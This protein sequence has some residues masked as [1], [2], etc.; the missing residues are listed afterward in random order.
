MNTNCFNPLSQ[1]SEKTTVFE[2][3]IIRQQP[4]IAEH[5]NT[6]TPAE[7]VMCY[8][9]YRA[10]L[11]CNHIL[12]DQLHRHATAIIDL[13]KQLYQ[14]R[15]TLQAALGSQFIEDMTMYLV[16]VATNH[17]QYFKRDQGINK[18]T[19]AAL[20][21]K[22]LTRQNLRRAIAAARI[23]FDGTSLDEL[24]ESIFSQEHEPALTVTGS[25]EH[26]AT[27]FHAPG[28]TT[29]LF[30]NTIDP[31]HRVV[32]ACYH[33]DE[34]NT[35]ICI[36]CYVGGHYHNELAVASHWFNIALEHAHRYPDLFDEHFT[37][38]LEHLIAFIKTGDEN[39]FKE[40]FKEW[41]KTNSR[42][43]Y[44]FGFIETYDDPMETTGSMQGE[45][46]IKHIS[47]Q[48]LSA[49]LPGIENAL[50]V[51]DAFKRKNMNVLPNASVNVQLY[52][53]G[54]LG[55][56]VITLAYC[57]P[58]YP[59]IRSTHG[60]KQIMYSKTK[61]VAET[62][63]P[64][65]TLL[66]NFSPE[67]IAWLNKHDPDKRMAKEIRE[68]LTFLHETIG[69]ASGSL[70]T[71][72]FTAE[73]NRK[74]GSKTYAI[75][76]TIPVT[77]ENLTHFLLGYDSTLEELRAEIIALYVATHHLD[78]LV[79]CGFLTE[80]VEKLGKKTVREWILHAMAYHGIYRL[81]GQSAENQYIIGAHAQANAVITNFL[82]DKK[83]TKLTRIPI[84]VDGENH[85]SVT[86]KI[87]DLEK[88]LAATKELMQLVQ[89][90]KST[91]DGSG[92][93]ELIEQ[94]G[95]HIDSPDLK[96]TLIKNRKTLIGNLRVFATIYPDLIPIL[97]P[98]SGEII[99]V[100]AQWP[101]D[102][103]EQI[104]NEDKR[105]FSTSLLP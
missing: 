21:L 51:P 80:W 84:T 92:A 105:A 14:H 79:Q 39:L 56:L 75:G 38:S 11:P 24:A 81:A 12:A 49:I 91:G 29:E 2:E 63:N 96:E 86:L 20:G 90:I 71:H 100:Q 26:S 25:I 65:K 94:L 77:D 78:E 6:L 102:V 28:M 59:D 43:D 19:P 3:I 42:I 47:L 62:V 57:L 52:G 32:H 23:R 67:Q 35:P 17:G 95:K 70:A 89:R 53:T 74:I 104:M 55:P 87:V 36:P 41:I 61:S 8:Y 48:Q 69:H 27:H 83:A 60:S 66:F 93:K 103:I 30:T 5:F 54:G 16:Y 68:L 37:R 76:D 58:N 40:H 46:T 1:A 88:G 82:L 15:D 73:E 13:F 4:G 85:E 31:A 98:T 64:E 72:T 7:R 97:D 45:I 33:L 99:D 10:I 50:P 18:R 101:T 34:H 44:S 22:T 9:L